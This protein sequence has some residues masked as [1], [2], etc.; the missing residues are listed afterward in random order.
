[1]SI[2]FLHRSTGSCARCGGVSRDGQKAILLPKHD[3]P[4]RNQISKED[5]K[6]FEEV[7]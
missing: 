6:I 5:E 1:M 2:D 3:I 4:Q 7:C